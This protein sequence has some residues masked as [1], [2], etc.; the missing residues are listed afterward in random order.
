[1]ASAQNLCQHSDTDGT[2][3]KSN[4]YT[5]CPHCQLQVCLKHLNH[6]QDLLRLDLHLFCDNVNRVHSDLD[7]LIFDST[8]QCR[9]LFEQLD[10][11]YHERIKSID[12]IYMERKQQL[13]VLCLQA[14]IEF[15][16]YKTKKDKQLKNNLLRQLRKVLKQKQIHIEDLNRMKNKLDDIER[17]LDEL[18]QLL[19]DIYPDNITMDIHIIKRPYKVNK[20]CR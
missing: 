2:Q 7:N 20:V 3:C 5:L 17:G 19:I 12:K 6:H 14:Q 13:Q 10:T 11:W 9:Q 4:E 16:T 1:M 18:K 15:E 8:D